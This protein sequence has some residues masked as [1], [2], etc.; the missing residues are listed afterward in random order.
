MLSVSKKFFKKK[1]KDHST[2]RFASSGIPVFDCSSFSNN[3]SF[4]NVEFQKAVANALIS[5]GCFY[6][7]NHGFDTTPLYAS[8]NSF[9][10]LQQRE[11]ESLHARL[12]DHAANSYIPRG[13][14]EV[15]GESLNADRPCVKESFDMGN[16]LGND[17][18]K[19]QWPAIPAFSETV[20]KNYLSLRLLNSKLLAAVSAGLGLD[21]SKLP[22]LAPISSS[23]TTLRFLHYIERDM[24]EAEMSDINED[25]DIVRGGEHTD[26]FLN[27]LIISKEPGL[28]IRRNDDS[29]WHKVPVVDSGKAILFFGADLLEVLTNGVIK[30]GVH[31]VIVDNSL[32][33]GNHVYPRQSIALFNYVKF[34]E[35]V[36]PLE[37]FV[38]SD[39]PAK[40]SPRTQESQSHDAYQSKFRL[41]YQYKE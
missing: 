6:I 9:F 2:H 30:A 37:E 22:S 4:T 24:T 18:K 19:N 21:S 38:A 32:I 13:Y 12:Q 15:H 7:T 5:T 17:M 36:Q 20:E 14:I 3:D 16:S 23:C 35:I 11:K 28:R 25:G 27:T 33:R 41:K 40:Y 1:L 29:T 10:S 39:K 31:Q 8:S 34:G 26:T